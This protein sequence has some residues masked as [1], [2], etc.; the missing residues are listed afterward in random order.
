MKPWIIRTWPAVFLLPL[1]LV[2]SCERVDTE[3]EPEVV[4]TG[5]LEE[6]Y[7][8]EGPYAVE[9]SRHPVDDETVK[10]Y[11]VWYPLEMEKSSERWP[12]VVMA[13]G[14]DMPA[15]SYKDVFRHLASWGFIVVGTEDKYAWSGKTC[16]QSLDFV[17]GLNEDPESIFFGKVDPDAVGIAG[18]SQG[19]V[20]VFN[21]LTGYDN[22]SR[23]K[24][25]VS[26]SCPGKVQAGLLSWTYDVSKV[27]VPLLLTAGTGLIDATVICPLETVQANF[28]SARSVP[29]AMGRKT[30]IDHGDMLRE[31][32]AYLAAW[33]LF[34]LRGD[35]LAANCFLGETAEILHN[36]RWQDTASRNL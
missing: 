13:N 9:M 31:G 27:R 18:H 24:A 21:A 30:G 17:L 15:S 22:G 29:V 28:D 10:R 12:L 11:Q 1:L 6:K 7:A 5:E 36:D 8:A 16:S 23:Y 34:W 2:P 26:A 19:G 3:P 20:A 4:Y 25:A 32:E 35:T 33:F 14:T